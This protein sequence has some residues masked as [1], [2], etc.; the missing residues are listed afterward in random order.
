MFG[1]EDRTAVLIGEDGSLIGP[2]L[3]G[4][5]DDL[6][7]IKTDQGTE[8]RQGAYFI[9]DAQGGQGLGSDLTDALAGDQAQAFAPLRQQ[10][11][12]PHHIAAHDDGQLVMGTFLIYIELD[13]CKVDVM[14]VDGA[15]VFRYL[16]CQVFDLA[17]SPFAGIRRG[18]EIDRV[19]L[20]ASL[21][22]HV[23]GDRG[24]DTAGQQQHGL[25]ADA[26][27]QTAGTGNHMGIH[28]ELLPD[29][30]IEHDLGIMDIHLQTGLRLQ[31]GM[32]HFGVDLQGIHR[33]LLIEPPGMDLKGMLAV[34]IL[35]ID[36]IDGLRDQ[37]LR[38]HDFADPD[39]AD[40]PDSEDFAEPL[41]HFVVI[42]FGQTVDKDPAVSLDHGKTAFAELKGRLDL[43]DQG[44][45]EHVP[46]LALNADLGIF[47][48]K[49]LIFHL[50]IP[51]FLSGS[52][53]FS[54]AG[55]S[56]QE[57]D[58][59]RDGSC[60]LSYIRFRIHD[61]Q[62]DPDGVVQ[63]VSLQADGGKST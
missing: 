10:L 34:R 38:G 32:S 37:F 7:L 29:L 3:L 58:Q 43:P 52:A 4:D 25:A 30:D 33:I 22:D 26:A 13:L 21:G 60:R 28:G 35:L 24:I 48:K 40:A 56:A 6:L 16:L 12:D 54:M 53:V 2:D 61:R 27:G 17:Q 41:D 46:V 9:G 36:K 39:R 42:I 5:R 31:N 47:N 20:D 18:V 23:A 51:F 63:M 59:L 55:I 49:R 57:R 50:C 1:H 14:Q 44:V 45:L 62:A 15:C 11:G 19:Q 8:D